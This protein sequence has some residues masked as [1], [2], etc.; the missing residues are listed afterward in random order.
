MAPRLKI[1]M[2]WVQERNPDILFLFKNPSKEP[3]PGSPAGPVWRE[4]PVY[5]A[6]AHLSK[7]SQKFL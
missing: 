7:T 6:F 3:P 2:S 5:R 1:L 4:I